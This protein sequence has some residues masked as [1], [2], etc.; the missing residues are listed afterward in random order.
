MN[1]ELH[2][3]ARARSCWS[4]QLILSSHAHRF[5]LCTGRQGEVL[6]YKYFDD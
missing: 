5:L 6:N 3:V 2:P 4:S 1:V